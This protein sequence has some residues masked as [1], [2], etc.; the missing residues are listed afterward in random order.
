MNDGSADPFVR[1]PGQL[2]TLLIGAPVDDKMLAELS[3]SWPGLDG[4]RRQMAEA[5]RVFVVTWDPLESWAPRPTAAATVNAGPPGLEV[6]VYVPLWSLYQAGT[7]SFRPVVEVIA[8]LAGSAVVVAADHPESVV[9]GRYLREV[10]AGSVPELL[11]E[12]QAG[13]RLGVP[14]LSLVSPGWEPIGLGAI[15]DVVQDAFGPVDLDRSPVELAAAMDPAPGCAACR[16]GRFGF[17]GELGEATPSLCARHRSEAERVTSE[18]LK[19]AA[20][21]NPDGWGAVISACERLGLP[22]LPNG[23][24][25]K[26]VGAEDAMF[27]LP[28]PDELAAEAHTVVEA[29]GWF[30]GR[31][32]D[33]ALALGAD[34]D[35]PWLPEWLRN[36][37]LDL[38]HVGRPAEAVAVAEAL[39]RVDP[40]NQ[41]EYTADLAVSLATAGDVAGA[42]SRVESNIQH[43]PDDLWVRIHA[44]DALMILGDGQA[45]TVH[46]LAALEMAEQDDDFEVRS[47]IVERLARVGHR[48][49]PRTTLK[50]LDA[51][52]DSASR[53]PARPG[54]N[55][56]CSCGSGRKYKHCHGRSTP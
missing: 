11:S 55:E 31:P 5:L 35:A 47:D 23:L 50:L 13:A 44:G 15:T 17:P 27:E 34:A 20:A 37:V 28:E 30:R 24:A 16:G 49:G 19:R 21:S 8:E 46:F 22:H 29:A 1:L 18:R 6:V 54:R 51:G 2:K 56:P 7:G 36:L 45:A 43:W 39:C 48:I 3:V 4:A 25:T 40:N 42:R 33:F 32:D 14:Q 53:A 12:R 38:G 41:A 26:L 10:R 52:R 9:A